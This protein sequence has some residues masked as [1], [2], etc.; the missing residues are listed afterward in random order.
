[1]PIT[2]DRLGGHAGLVRCPGLKHLYVDNVYILGQRW[3]QFCNTV[4]VKGVHTVGAI[5]MLVLT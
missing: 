1:M 5:G 4:D 3:M 2:C